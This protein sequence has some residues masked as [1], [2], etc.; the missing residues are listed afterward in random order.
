[1]LTTIG[2]KSRIINLVTAALRGV[3]NP[4]S[5]PRRPTER[6]GARTLSVS[7]ALSLLSSS[8]SSASAK[9]QTV[10]TRYR[11]S[12]VRVGRSGV[13]N[14]RT[15]TCT[16]NARIHAVTYVSE[17]TFCSSSG[18]ISCL[19]HQRRL[20]L[21]AARLGGPILCYGTHRHRFGGRRREDAQLT[22]RSK[23]RRRGGK[24]SRVVTDKHRGFLL[25]CF[26]LAVRSGGGACEESPF[27]HYSY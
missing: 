7:T 22:G 26:S 12:G 20:F 23:R 11:C 9:K 13:E 14:D 16:L 1:M 8:L 15:C 17:V 2:H 18:F 21:D 6:E 4:I 10:A 24:N 25:H 27:R 19:E 5:L 3:P